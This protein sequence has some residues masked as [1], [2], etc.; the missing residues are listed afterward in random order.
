L[1]VTGLRA[2]GYPSVRRSSTAFFVPYE[3]LSDKLQQIQRQGG[4]IVSVTPA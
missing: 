4:K 3:R 2:P 1:E